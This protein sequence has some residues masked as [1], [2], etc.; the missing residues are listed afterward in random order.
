[1][2]NVLRETVNPTKGGFEKFDNITLSVINGKFAYCDSNT[3]E[4]AIFTDNGDENA[5]L[6]WDFDFENSQLIPLEDGSSK[7]FNYITWDEVLILK[8]AIEELC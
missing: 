7:T 4:A 6:W 8:K 5:T 3:F 2:A 1:M